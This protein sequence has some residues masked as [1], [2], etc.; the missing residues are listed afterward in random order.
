MKIYILTGMALL[1]FS[2]AN[3][4]FAKTGSQSYVCKS[5][6]EAWEADVSIAPEKVIFKDATGPNGKGTLVYNKVNPQ[7]VHNSTSFLKTYSVFR[8]SKSESTAA[9]ESNNDNVIYL[10]EPSL[11]SGG[12]FGRIFGKYQPGAGGSNVIDC[13]LKL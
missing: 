4:A 6:N 1:H 12:K 3:T 7:P 9:Y 13:Y 11:L 8:L 10:V 5:R 2:F